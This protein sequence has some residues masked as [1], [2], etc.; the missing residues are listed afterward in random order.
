M[1]LRQCSI[2]LLNKN[3]SKIDQ[4]YRVFY[5]QNLKKDCDITFRKE[6]YIK[7]LINYSRP[8]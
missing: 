3:S 1:A 2:T 8:T 5:N 7:I 6:N 4:F